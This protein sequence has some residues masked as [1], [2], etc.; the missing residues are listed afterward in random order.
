MSGE[1]R[2]RWLWAVGG[3]VAIWMTLPPLVVIPMSFSDRRSLAFPPTGY[4]LQWYREFFAN[5]IWLDSLRASVSIALFVVLTSVLL[6]SLAAFGLVR[7]DFRGRSILET[8]GITPLIVP[9][10]VFGLGTYAAFLRWDLVGTKLGFV[11]AHTVLSVPFVIITVSTSLRVMDRELERAAMVLGAK[12]RRVLW[13]VTLPVIAPGMTAGALFAFVTSFDEV[14]VALFISNPHLRTLP[15]VMYSSV[16]RD[17]D[18]TIAAASTIILVFTTT[19]I[20]VGTRFALS[21]RE[22]DSSH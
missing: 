16:T 14:V 4:S 19:V 6:G 15:V 9:L 8:V 12:P 21:S 11:A 22:G 18:P 13:R 5:P 3:A 20:L 7:G 1:R 2:P 10:V 17:I